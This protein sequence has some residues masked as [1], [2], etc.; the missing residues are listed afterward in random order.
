MLL[1]DGLNGWWISRLIARADQLA[2]VAS[3]VMGLAVSAVSL[4]VA[5]LG[6]GKLLSPAVERWTDGR[7][8]A[9][10]AVVVGVI[11]AGYAAGFAAARLLSRPSGAASASSSARG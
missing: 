11:A 5:G 9:F 8:L 6:V 2:A 7:E 4:L 10:G 3:R 1:A